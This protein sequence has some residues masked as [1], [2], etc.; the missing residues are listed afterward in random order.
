MDQRKP[1]VALLRRAAAEK[2]EEVQRLESAISEMKTQVFDLEREARAARYPHEWEALKTRKRN[3]ESSLATLDHSL[4]V[5]KAEKVQLNER[6]TAELRKPVV[7][8]LA[9]ERRKRL[10]PPTKTPNRVQN[11]H[12]LNRLASNA[13]IFH[14]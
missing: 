11:Y 8:S 13:S 2:D 6:L 5:A 10:V 1:S 9:A 14:A 7:A 3:L 12:L 4:E